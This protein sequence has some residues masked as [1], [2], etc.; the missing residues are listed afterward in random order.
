MTYRCSLLTLSIAVCV[1]GAS[2]RAQTPTP[3]PTPTPAV[4]DTAKLAPVVT[5]A[6]PLMREIDRRI[7]DSATL[8]NMSTRDRYLRLQSDNRYLEHVLKD[9][10]KR[11]EQLERRLAMLK[12]QREKSRAESASPLRNENEELEQ[13]MQ[14]LD[15]ITTSQ[16]EPSG[17][18]PSP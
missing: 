9:Q 11:I 14:R 8:A 2:A 15:R 17:P 10:D 18:P 1:A 12:E 13:R 4:T 6:D 5:V 3:T 16:A 7:A